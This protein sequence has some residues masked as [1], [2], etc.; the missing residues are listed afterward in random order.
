MRYGLIVLW[1]LFC[2]VT[3]SAVAQVSIGIG[4]PGVSIGVNLP[5]YPEFVR[6][7]GYPVY[8]APRLHSNYF[9]Y[10]GMYWV[11]QGDNWYASSWYNGPWG[12]VAPEFVPLFILR[13]PVR[14]YRVPPAYFLRWRLDAPPRW[15]EH[16]GN[17]WERHRRGWDKWDRRSAPAPAPLPVYQRRYSG[18]RYPRVEQQH[19]LRSRNY[20]YQPR[21][22]IVRRH[23]R[24][25]AVQRTPVPSQRQQQERLRD[26]S[27]RQPDIQ[28]PNPPSPLQQR[29]PARSQPPQNRGENVQR[30]AP[31]QAPPQ[32][33]G[34]A[35]Q[36][37]QRG[38]R[39]SQENI[40]DDKGAPRDPRRGQG[41][42]KDWKEGEGRGQE[43]N[44]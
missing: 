43:R 13:I 25:Q 38:A 26:R 31:I 12:L 18:N 11:Y 14:Y 4:L 24:E 3:S 19:E 37:E 40:R 6:V 30:A 39:S 22:A 27:P 44:R 36:R 23:Y 35:V 17:D 34:L 15:G 20:R 10:D 7:P 16:W 8:Y 1:M 32:Q 9:F 5:V 33:R 28:R 42:E 21:D 2:S 29:G 41:R